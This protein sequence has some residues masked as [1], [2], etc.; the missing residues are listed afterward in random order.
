MN[1]D[2]EP[3]YAPAS[4][5]AETTRLMTL[6]KHGDRE[7]FDTLAERIRGHA[8]RVAQSLVGSRDDALEL[9]QEALLKTYRAR[10]TYRDGEPFL[11]WFQRI[12]RNT[13]YS[14]MRGKG[15]LA[16]ASLSP[17][18]GDPAS[19]DEADWQIAD[20]DARDPIDPLIED[21]RARI[22]WSAFRKLGAR[23]REI[24]ALRHFEELPYDDIAAVLGIPVGTVMSRLFHARRRLREGLGNALDE[25]IEPQGGLPGAAGIGPRDA[26]NGKVLR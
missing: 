21:E 23:D 26:R 20:G 12:V 24:L 17:R 9:S 8:F 3:A 25:G 1:D 2:R 14:W 5:Q 11:P 19:D 4:M 10:E 7:A 13:C 16:V 18:H 6:A 15:K 22:F